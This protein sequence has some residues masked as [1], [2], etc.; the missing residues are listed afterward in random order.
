MQ[1]VADANNLWLM[2][3]PL[4]PGGRHILAVTVV[5]PFSRQGHERKPRGQR[6]PSPPPSWIS[7]SASLACPSDRRASTPESELNQSL[8]TAGMKEEGLRATSIG[9]T[10]PEAAACLDGAAVLACCSSPVGG[11]LGLQVQ[12][13][14]ARCKRPVGDVSASV[15]GTEMWRRPGGEWN[16]FA[17]RIGG[18]VGGAGE[19]Q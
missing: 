8:T 1:R 14:R 9:P 4:C 5:L 10:S 7:V 17:S 19:G 15:G 2:S 12:W 16:R 18:E 11:R 6:T 3:P 13:R